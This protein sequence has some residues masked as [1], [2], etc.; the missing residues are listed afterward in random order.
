MRLELIRTLGKRAVHG[1][2]FQQ[3]GKQIWNRI[4]F[5][6][7][8]R[9]FQASYPAAEYVLYP[10]SRIAE[11]RREGFK[12]QFG[13]DHYLWNKVLERR[14]SGTFADIGANLPVEGSNSYYLEKHGWSGVAIDP[15]RSLA[16]KWA[17]ERSARFLN[18]AIS[19]K[20]E[21]RRFVEVKPRD[22]WEHA[23]SAFKGMV[24]PED[25]AIY[26]TEEYDVECLPLSQALP[27]GFV[28]DL[29]LIDVEGAE[30]YVVAGM[31]FTHQRPRFILCENVSE[32]GGS[33]ALRQSIEAKGYRIIARIGASDD[34]FERID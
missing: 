2:V 11:F 7:D 3:F 24:R 13:Q 26:E 1:T 5:A 31:D 30:P 34:L 21:T 20:A 6:A 14:A 22:G 8:R 25:L 15:Q 12:S 32:P 19:D 4:K 18:N 16:Q 9:R 29:L 33:A 23:L 28:P 17:Q 10:A 27:A